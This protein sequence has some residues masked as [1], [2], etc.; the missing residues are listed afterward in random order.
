MSRTLS[1]NDATLADAQVLFHKTAAGMQIKVTVH[2]TDGSFHASYDEDLS[3]ALAA[4]VT[5]GTITSA[6][7]TA[8]VAVAQALRARAR[9]ALSLD[10]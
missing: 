5:A 8:F 2:S 9:A 6:Q 7:R 10:V 3:T 1:T 4:M